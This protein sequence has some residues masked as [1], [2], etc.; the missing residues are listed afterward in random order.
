MFREILAN[1]QDALWSWALD[2]ID[3][4]CSADECR[5]LRVFA[6][7]RCN[8]PIY[9]RVLIER[10]RELPASDTLTAAVRDIYDQQDQDA[11]VRVAA[12]EY[13][14]RTTHEE[15]YFEYLLGRALTPRAD[16]NAYDD[17]PAAAIYALIGIGTENPGRRSQVADVVR[18]LLQRIPKD[19]HPTYS[20]LESLVC[21]LGRAGGP[22]D[23]PLLRQYCEQSSVRVAA[24]YG[25]A[26]IDAPLALEAA[27]RHVAS[28]IASARGQ[29]PPGNPNRCWNEV[30]EY[31]GLFVAFGDRSAVE[32]YEEFLKHLAAHS[33][34]GYELTY[35]RQRT[36]SMLKVLTAKTPNEELD[37]AAEH[38]RTQGP[39]IYWPVYDFILQKLGERLAQAAGPKAGALERLKTA[40]QAWR[41][42]L[43]TRR[44]E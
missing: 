40:S 30:I 1:D 5:S 25:L 19:S 4:H 44:A 27:R 24:A 14:F 7:T 33:E 38:V 20:Q 43:K 22:G 21:F 12:A 6:L 2:A 31:E 9:L 28:L 34:P 3:A 15:R 29:G 18:A 10:L 13:L 32:F 37:L 26:Q 16:L 36:E 35:Y 11:R 41:D 23:V 17:P 42:R 39:G 8:D